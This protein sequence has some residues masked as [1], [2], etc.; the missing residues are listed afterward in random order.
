MQYTEERLLKLS[1]VAQRHAPRC[2]CRTQIQELA[3]ALLAHPLAPAEP[4]LMAHQPQKQEK[5]LA[6]DAFLSA[7]TRVPCAQVLPLN[8]HDLLGIR[9]GLPGPAGSAQTAHSLSLGLPARLNLGLTVRQVG[10][11]S[12]QAE[13]L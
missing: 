9:P 3:S 12:T 11:A 2:R 10:T 6:R 4:T 5:L 1:R 7:K 13:A 8:H